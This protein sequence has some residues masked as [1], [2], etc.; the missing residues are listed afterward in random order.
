[1]I[2]M[3]HAWL[4]DNTNAKEI[5]TADTYGLLKVVNAEAGRLFLKMTTQ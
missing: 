1:M 4:I 2:Q 3:K 5:K